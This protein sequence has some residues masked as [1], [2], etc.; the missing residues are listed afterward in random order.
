MIVRHQL[1]GWVLAAALAG[2]GAAQAQN[3]TSLGTGAL[4]SG[5]ATT[6]NTAVGFDALFADDAGGFNTAVGVDSL[7]FNVGAG[8]TALGAGALFN[9]TTGQTNAAVGAN[10]LSNNA[11]G[12]N[13]TAVGASAMLDN[14]SGDDNAAVGFLA[15]ELGETGSG[16]TALGTQALGQVV[17][18]SNDVAVGWKA[19]LSYTAA[20]SND[21]VVGNP[22]SP[23]D[24]GVIRIGTHGVHSTAFI[25]GI[26]GSALANGTEVFVNR[27]GELGTV[28]S[29]ARFKEGVAPMGDVSADL[30]KLRPVTFYYRPGIDD[31]SRLLQYGLVA[32]EVARVDPGLVQLD[33]DGRPLAVRYHFV[34]AMVLHEVQAQH[35]TI[36]SQQQRLDAQAA[37]IA[38]QGATIAQQGTLIEQLA[39]RL[40]RLERPE[41]TGADSAARNH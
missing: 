8:N 27:K 32:E 6:G 38:N 20:E 5:A 29:S 14:G 30:M 34:N 15:L 36:A 33:D 26:F 7:S 11:S 18:G 2:G 21:I 28:V 1:M 17:S 39:A 31:G 37:L 10:T 13:N 35:A 24:Q 25:A 4:D 22:G 40:A 23:G 41:T 12:S 3:N 9:S 19:G 16:N